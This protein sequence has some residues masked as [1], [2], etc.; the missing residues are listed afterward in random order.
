MAASIFLGAVC[1]KGV[2]TSEP[3]EIEGKVTEVLP[4]VLYRVSLNDGSEIVCHASTEV[5]R[6]T[7]QILTGDV[8]RVARSTFDASRGRIVGTAK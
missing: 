3:A 4:D 5:R 6:H 8:V 2:D 7:V 1:P